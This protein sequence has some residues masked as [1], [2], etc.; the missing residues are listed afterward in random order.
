MRCLDIAGMVVAERAAHAFR[1]SVIRDDISVVRELF[2]ADRTNA[3]LLND[4][5]AEEFSHLCG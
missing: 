1:I 2:V 4:F 3:V 5:P